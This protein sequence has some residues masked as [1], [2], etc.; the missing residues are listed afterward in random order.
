MMAGISDRAIKSQ[1]VENKFR[2]NDGS[3]LQ[4][5]EFSDGS[6][7]EMYDPGFRNYDP[8]IGKFHQIDPLAEASESWSTYSFSFDNPVAFNDPTGL[9]PDDI[10]P[11]PPDPAPAPAPTPVCVACN[12]TPIC[13]ACSVGPPDPTPPPGVTPSPAPDAPAQQGYQDLDKATLESYYQK[14]CV[15]C[16]PGQLQN[17]VGNQF[18]DAWNRAAKRLLANDNYTPNSTPMSGG[19]RNTVPDG[20][21][22]GYLN[23]LWGGQIRVPGAAWFEVKAK[24][25]D[26]YNST[27]TGQIMGH[28]TNLAARV[29]FQYRNYGPLKASAA[30][31]TFV[32]TSDV[33]IAPS[34]ISTA[35]TFNIIIYQYKA[36][37]MM[38][39][40]FMS[41]IF[42]LSSQNGIGITGLS[43]APVIMR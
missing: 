41:V 19:T 34:V 10:V 15:T 38:A 14:I 6:G 4:N 40:N 26:I 33:S 39:G 11:G 35:S 1:Y 43:T 8:Q 42:T 25:G 21:A 24:N 13:V 23:K 18:E 3:E 37:Y 29:P 20:T 31:L 9:S 16:S 22:D 5:K 17:V 2:F 36:Q 28:I 7:L 27:S 32:T 12:P 30:S